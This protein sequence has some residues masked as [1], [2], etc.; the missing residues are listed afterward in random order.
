M[1]EFEK[2]DSPFISRPETFPFAPCHTY[3]WRNTR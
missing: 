3:D 1:A 2:W